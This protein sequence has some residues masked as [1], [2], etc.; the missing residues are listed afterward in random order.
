MSI[1]LLARSDVDLEAESSSC[2]RSYGN[3]ARLPGAKGLANCGRALQ[4]HPPWGRA[5]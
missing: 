2:L 3:S 5:A 1:S 4:K